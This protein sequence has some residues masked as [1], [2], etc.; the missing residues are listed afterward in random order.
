MNEALEAGPSSAS[1]KPTFPE[2]VTP[3]PQGMSKN[4]M[5]KAARKVRCAETSEQPG[6]H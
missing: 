6:H 4:A 1:L 2:G 3:P 5:K